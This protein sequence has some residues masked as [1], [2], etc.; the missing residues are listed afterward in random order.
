LNNKIRDLLGVDAVHRC[1]IAFFE[2][3]K[4]QICKIDVRQSKDPVFLNGEFFVRMNNQT[5]KLSTLEFHAYMK[6]RSD[7]FNWADQ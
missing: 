4:N 2:I 5:G 6:R 1:R 7:E 3:Q